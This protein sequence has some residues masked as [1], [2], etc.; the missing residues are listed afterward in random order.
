MK[1]PIDIPA[2]GCPEPPDCALFDARAACAIARRAAID[3]AMY[4]GLFT[5]NA[6]LVAAIRAGK[7]QHVFID[8]RSSDE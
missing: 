2:F 5:D 1:D 6:A 4:T 3:A 7:I 8:S